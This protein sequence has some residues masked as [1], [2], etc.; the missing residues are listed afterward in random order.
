[1]SILVE[2]L[3]NNAVYVDGT[4]ITNR[5]TKYGSRKTLDSFEVK[6]KKYVAIALIMRDWYDHLDSISNKD[7]YGL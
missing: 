1:M 3:E 6:H 4:R 5:S 7:E 2:V